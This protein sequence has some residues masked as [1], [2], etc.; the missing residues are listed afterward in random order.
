MGLRLRAVRADAEA[1]A[2]LGDING[3]IDRLRAGQRLAR[4]A[5]ATGPDAIE[6]SMIDA[7]ARELSA[8]HRELQPRGAHAPLR[9]PQRSKP[10]STSTSTAMAHRLYSKE[11]ISAATKP[12]TCRRWQQARGRPEHQGVDDED[13]EAERDH[14]DRQRQQQQDGPQHAVEQ[15][16]HERRDQRRAEA[17]D[18]DPGVQVRHQQQCACEQ[19][20]AN[21]QLDHAIEHS[22]ARMHQPSAPFAQARETSASLATTRSRGSSV[23]QSD[24]WGRH[25]R[26]IT[27]T[28][29]PSQRE[30]CFKTPCTRIT[31]R[32]AGCL[33]ESWLMQSRPHPAHQQL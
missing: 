10:R 28:Y 17:G 25:S 27:R 20:P 30:N 29:R 22:S 7:R 13:E 33:R 21:D 8:L 23:Q 1:R 26:L 14:G 12:L 6:A 11:P 16:E 5:A 18:G 19:R 24:A 9:P 4:E 3:A 31:I 15:S 32:A 2:E